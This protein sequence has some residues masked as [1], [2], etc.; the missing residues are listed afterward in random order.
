MNP[1]QA[2]GG[3]VIIVLSYDLQGK[4][5]FKM[6]SRVLKKSK[7][8]QLKLKVTEMAENLEG[9]LN[10]SVVEVDKTEYKNYAIKLQPSQ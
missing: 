6:P 3:S 10:F 9:E 2:C 7:I 8:H 4:K 1:V 5:H